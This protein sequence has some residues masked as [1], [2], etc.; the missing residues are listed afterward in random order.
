MKNY[1]SL[2]FGAA[3][4]LGIWNL[5][6]ASSQ[7]RTSSNNFANNIEALTVGE[8][9]TSNTGPGKIYDCPGWGTGDGKLCMCENP[10]PCT[11]VPC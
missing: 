6:F 10:Y 11:Q 3:L 7:E 5:T 2:L 9:S 4:C 8:S 1:L